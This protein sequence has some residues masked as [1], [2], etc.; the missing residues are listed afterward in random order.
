MALRAPCGSAWV[1]GIDALT[2][3]CP[4]LAKAGPAVSHLFGWAG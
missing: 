3:V 4:M 2:S 1:E